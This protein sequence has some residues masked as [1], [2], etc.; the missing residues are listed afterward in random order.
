MEYYDDEKSSRPKSQPKSLKRRKDV[1]TDKGN[2]THKI[3][4]KKDDY[5]AD[6]PPI[7]SRRSMENINVKGLWKKEEDA[8]L[9]DLVKKYGP[10]D[11]TKQIS[12]RIAG[13]NGKQCRERWFN[14]LDPSISKTAWTEDEDQQL[15]DLHAKLGNR[16]AE[17][18]K[19]IAGRPS[20]AIKNHWHTSVK[21]K[22][23]SSEKSHEKNSSPK[24]K[25]R[26]TR[27][28]KASTS[29]CEFEDDEFAEEEAL[30]ELES[31]IEEDG[32]SHSGPDEPNLDDDNNLED[33]NNFEED[34]NS[35]PE[36]INSGD[37]QPEFHQNYTSAIPIPNINLLAP[38]GWFDADQTNLTSFDAS[39]FGS[40]MISAIQFSTPRKITV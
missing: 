16:W 14:N 11:W 8:L 12:A 1:S 9:I 36:E 17:I 27:K 3:K 26:R 13:R 35:A 29:D 21:K 10:K 20:N 7:K 24:S 31:L 33:D 6:S 2:E 5:R 18:S 4:K 23:E 22:V 25:K 34:N 28:A 19:Y 40:S 38:S 32:S 15:I 37:E 30:L 39:P